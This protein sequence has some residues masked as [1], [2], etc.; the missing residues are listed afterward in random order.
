M[1][2]PDKIKIGGHWYEIK[3]PYIFQERF[4]R[5][6]Q[7]DAVKKIIYITDKD[8][9]GEK[10]ANSHILCTFIHEIIHAIDIQSGHRTFDG[11]QGEN[12]IEGLS[13]GIF[14]VLVDNGYLKNEQ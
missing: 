5:F 2:I 4:D 11:D 12:K 8:G 9:N 14:Q 13:E 1:K 6:G 3:Y 7:C 10:R